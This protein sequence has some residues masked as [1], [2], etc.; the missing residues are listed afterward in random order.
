MRM[1]MIRTDFPLSL[2][3][4]HISI[5]SVGAKKVRNTI[6]TEISL[7]VVFSCPIYLTERA[8]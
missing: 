4:I 5:L 8:L 7:Q 2:K 3:Y 6:V 1:A